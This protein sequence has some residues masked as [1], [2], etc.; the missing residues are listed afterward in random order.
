MSTYLG[1]DA[2]SLSNPSVGTNTLEDSIYHFTGYINITS[3]NLTTTFQLGSDDGSALW[4]NGIQVI[5]NDGD[6]SYNTVS[7]TVDFTRRGFTP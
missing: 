3:A 1:S 5:D 7:Q 4:L 2:A 6:H